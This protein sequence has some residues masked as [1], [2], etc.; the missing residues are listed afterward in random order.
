MRTAEVDGAACRAAREEA[1]LTQKTLAEKTS[2]VYGRR[3]AE[4]TIAHIETGRRQPSGGLFR[5]LCVVLRVPRD[6]LLVSEAA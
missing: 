5:A 2:K 4:S 3:V 1:G 6:R